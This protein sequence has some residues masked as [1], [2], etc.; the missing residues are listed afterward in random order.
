MKTKVNY[1][2]GKYKITRNPHNDD[3]FYLYLTS[4]EARTLMKKKKNGDS[5]YSELGFAEIEFIA[6]FI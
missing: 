6:S 4:Q 3:H 1:L 2:S 5:L